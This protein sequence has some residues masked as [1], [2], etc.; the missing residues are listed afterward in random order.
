MRRHLNLLFVCGAMM[1]AAMPAARAGQG[2]TPA[3]ALSYVRIGDLQFSPDGSKLAFVVASYKWD[4]RPR[5][6]VMDVATGNTRE[7]TPDGKAERSPQ[8]S[9]DGKTLAFLSNRNGKTQVYEVTAD[10]GNAAPLTGSKS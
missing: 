4:A 6:R 2:L 8:W 10:G 3:Q 5:L 7:L 9:P 1:A